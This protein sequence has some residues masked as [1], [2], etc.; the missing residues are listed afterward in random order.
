M[1][2][3]TAIG[4][5]VLFLAG[6]WASGEDYPQWRG[7]NRDGKSADTGLLKQWPE[8]GPKVLWSVKGLGGGYATVAVADG[9]IYTTGLKGANGVLLAYDLA[10]NPKWKKEYGPEWSK[11]GRMPHPGTRTTP[12][13]NDGLVYVCGAMGNLVCFDAK[14]GDRKWAVDTLKKFKGRNIRWGISESLLIDQDN[15]ICQPGGIG[16]GIVALNKKTGATVWVCKDVS[17]ASAYC[18]PIVVRRGDRR[19][20]VTVTAKAIV[21]VDAK[22]GKLI[23]KRPFRNK[24]AVHANTP[25]HHD[26]I[27]HVTSGYNYGGIAVELSKDGSETA[28]LWRNNRLAVHHG[29]VVQVD[30]YV[31]G[32]DNRSWVCQNLKTGEVMHQDKVVGKGSATYADGMLYCYGENGTLALVKATP[33]AFTTVSSFKIT[34]GDGQHWAHPV[35]SGGRLYIRHG[36]VL[37]AFDVRPPVVIRAN[38]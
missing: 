23:W 31:Y 10:G 8:G 3:C 14:T 34:Q 2:H 16:A 35:V 30:G 33:K 37:T 9:M 22:T 25:I 19:L 36:D 13:V 5:T 24:A 27:L 21:G 4:L 26:G 28:K 20:L 1:K 6:G 38:K 12:T 11:S 17:D 15:V 7:P 32:A 18:S 29:G